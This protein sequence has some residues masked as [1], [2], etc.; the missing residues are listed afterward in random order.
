MA[1][2]T[3][4]NTGERFYETG[5][6]HG[7]LY[8]PD[9]TGVYDTGVAWNGLV[10]VTE[11]PSGA[12]ASPQYADNIKYL[13][14]I[15]AEEFGATIEAFTY[16]DEFGQCD[17][18]ASP[19]VGVTL[20]QQTRRSFGLAYRTR[21]GNDTLGTDLGYKIHLIYGALAAPSEKAYSTIN[22]SPEALTFSWDVTTSPVIVGTI[23]TV[24][25]KPTASLTI[26]ST[27]AD[28]DALA[29]LEAIL[30]GT[31]GEDPS[32]PLPAAVIALFSGT[33]TLATPL[34]PTIVTE[35]NV[36][37]IPTITGVVYK[38]NGAIV[39]GALPAIT[40][41]VLVTAHAATGYYFPD[42]IDVDWLMEY[43]A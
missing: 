1:V 32:L 8:T 16:P 18:T 13:N 34:A 41:D 14:L 19:E 20:G 9:E 10:S 31:T 17:G 3:W 38:I 36:I 28:A 27:K 35:T 5:L 15:S 39:S 2:L 25:Y 22:D 30:F 24:T 4:D 42:V 33:L 40:D 37:T 11:S 7:V 21:V 26:D 12:E 43:T 23:D 29:A 6:D